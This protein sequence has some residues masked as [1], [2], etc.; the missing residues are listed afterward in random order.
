MIWYILVQFTYVHHWNGVS[1]TPEEHHC[2]NESAVATL[3]SGVNS[4]IKNADW[5][6]L[7]KNVATDDKDCALHV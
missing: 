1:L 3:L 5:T 7:E 2:K 6:S 4:R